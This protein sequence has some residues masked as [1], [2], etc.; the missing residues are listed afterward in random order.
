MAVKA[1]RDDVSHFLVRPRYTTSV[2]S[3][4]CPH[5]FWRV[6]IPIEQWNDGFEAEE[7]RCIASR[8]ST[9]EQGR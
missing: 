3:L 1:S 2:D 7:L 5:S 8:A 9:R 4:A 6:G